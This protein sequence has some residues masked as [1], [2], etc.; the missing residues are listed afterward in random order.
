MGDST[1]QP[2][3]RSLRAELEGLSI[4]DQHRFAYHWAQSHHRVIDL[5]GAYTQEQNLVIFRSGN[6]SENWLDKQNRL[7]YKM[8]TLMH[9]GEDISKLLLRMELFNLLFPQSTMHLIGFYVYSETHVNPIFTQSFIDKARFATDEEITSFL[10][11]RGFRPT[12]K[13]GE[14]SD[15]TYVVSDARPKNVLV[16]ES[17][18]T[19][20]IDADVCVI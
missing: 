16:T 15:G 17:G 6:E 4:I 20:V 18:A 19:F 13:D 10:S 11:L 8:N 1:S 12:G 14:F 7:V 5:F 9:V 2:D 3:A